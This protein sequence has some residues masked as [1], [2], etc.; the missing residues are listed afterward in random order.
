MLLC[1]PVE[2]SC[3]PGNPERTLECQSQHCPVIMPLGEMKTWRVW[4]ESRGWVYYPFCNH[5]HFLASVSPRM[6]PKG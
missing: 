5:E 1:Q 3:P 6:L 4:V 2:A